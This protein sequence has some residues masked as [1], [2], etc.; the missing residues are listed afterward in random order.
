[1]GEAE[2]EKGWWFDSVVHQAPRYW[3]QKM[4]FGKADG[5]EVVGADFETVYPHKE[6]LR[7]WKVQAF[8][9]DEGKRLGI[10]IVTFEEWKTVG[11]EVLREMGEVL[12]ELV[13]DGEKRVFGDD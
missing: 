13:G 12:S 7:E 8:V 2:D 4:E 11:E 1:M 10:E 9:Q 3:V 5:G 6:P